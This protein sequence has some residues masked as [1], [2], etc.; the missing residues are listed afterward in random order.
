[1]RRDGVTISMEPQIDLFTLKILSL[2]MCRDTA[3]I[4]ANLFMDTVLGRQRKA[5]GRESIAVHDQ[6][7]KK[8]CKLL[9]FYSE[10]FPKKF[11]CEFKN[12]LDQEILQTKEFQTNASDLLFD[13]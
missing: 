13:D 5:L 7:V 9:L 8:A 12:E 4:K 10:I 3:K 2:L 1:M 11:E 6:R